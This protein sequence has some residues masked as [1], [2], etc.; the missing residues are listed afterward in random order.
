[1]NQVENNGDDDE[2]YVEGENDLAGQDAENGHMAPVHGP[3]NQQHVPNP[4]VGEEMEVDAIE[5]D[6]LNDDHDKPCSVQK[7]VK[8]AQKEQNNKI[9][10]NSSEEES[11]SASKSCCACDCHKN[12]KSSNRSDTSSSSKGSG[13]KS[14]DVQP[15]T[16]SCTPTS[17]MQLRPRSSTGVVTPKKEDQRRKDKDTGELEHDS[18]TMP[19]SCLQNKRR[20]SNQADQKGHESNKVKDNNEVDASSK[21]TSAEQ[22]KEPIKDRSET[23][24]GR[25]NVEKEGYA[26]SL[27]LETKLRRS[28]RLSRGH[29]GSDE[30]AAPK[31]PISPSPGSVTPVAAN[32]SSSDP[33]NTSPEPGQRKGKSWCVV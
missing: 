23:P 29:T 1:M 6:A 24:D 10:G 27:G 15:G 13:N 18:N 3:F 30:V 20:R 25:T 5:N 4:N 12:A 14:S 17:W 7:S 31:T 11:D 26:S 28:A 32:V 19:T 2:N 16:S 8:C 9:V 22:S 21:T 33:E